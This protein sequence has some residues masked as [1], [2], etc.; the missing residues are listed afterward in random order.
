MT[1]IHHVSVSFGYHY[2]IRGFI[3]QKAF[4]MSSLQPDDYF[5]L[6]KT[7]KS[8]KSA[9]R[10]FN[11]YWYKSKRGVSYD[12]TDILCDLVSTTLDNNPLCSTEEQLRNSIKYFKENLWGSRLTNAL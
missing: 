8:S 9:L 5:K 10:L 11:K 3:F 6:W 12:G 4:N 1:V 7:L 2:I